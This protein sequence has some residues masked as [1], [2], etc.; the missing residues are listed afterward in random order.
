MC[1]TELMFFT[2][3]L[4]FYSLQRDFLKGKEK[5]RQVRQQN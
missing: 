4:F 2:L 5:K 1:F 3:F